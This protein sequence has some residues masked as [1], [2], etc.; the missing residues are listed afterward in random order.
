MN[1]AGHNTKQG[2]EESNLIKQFMELLRQQDMSGQSQGF[3]EMFGYVAGMQL[4]LNMVADELQG[5]REQLTKL[6]ESQLF[7]MFPSY[8]GFY[9]S[10]FRCHRCQPFI[11]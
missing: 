1:I 5:M 4:Q 7:S 11:P 9:H 2:M 6:Q 8:A 3:M 10:L